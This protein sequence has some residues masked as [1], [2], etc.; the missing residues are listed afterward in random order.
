M[1]E[2]MDIHEARFSQVEAEN[3]TSVKPKLL[4]SYSGT[5][6]RKIFD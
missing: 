2:Q 4:A 6:K 1:K 5:Q 3:K